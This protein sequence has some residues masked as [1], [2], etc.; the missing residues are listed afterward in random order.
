[1]LII[2]YIRL[3]F[4]RFN[5]GII[6]GTTLLR[7]VKLNYTDSLILEDTSVTKG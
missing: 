7:Y 4:S 6:L 3:A 5:I 2:N 1:M